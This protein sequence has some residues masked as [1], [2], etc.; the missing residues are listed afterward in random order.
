MP[1]YRLGLPA[2]TRHNELAIPQGND[3]GEHLLGGATAH[4][5]DVALERLIE[6]LIETASSTSTR[7][8]P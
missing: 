1:S 8:L 2:R 3:H 6:R 7:S 4:A 5:V